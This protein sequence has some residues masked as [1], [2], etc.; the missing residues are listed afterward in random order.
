MRK[1]NLWMLAAILTLCGLTTTLTSCSDS[2]DEVQDKLTP[3][4]GGN[5]NTGYKT[6][7]LISDIHVMSPQLL[8]REGSAYSSYLNFDPKLL[9][10]SANVLESL[11]DEAIKRK[12]DLV[13]IPGDLTKDGELVS[14]QLVASIL[15]RLRTAGIPVILVPG[16]HD[17]DNPEGYYFNGDEKRSAE[18]TSPEMFKQIYADFGYNQAYATDPASLSFVCEPLEGLVLLCLDTNL[19]EE[20]LYKDRGDEKDYNQTAGRIRP[21]TLNWALDEA[22]KARALGKQVVLVEHH[23]I[24]Q[25][26]DAQGSIQSEY[27]IPDYQ[28]ISEKMGKHGVH[29]AFTGHTHLQDIAAYKYYDA[30][31][32]KTDSIVDVATGSTVS[33]PNPWRV[34]RVSDDYTRWEI[35]TEY[36]KSIPQL[37]DVQGTCYKRLYDNISGG[38]EWH[39]DYAWD[40]IK[41]YQQKGYLTLL[42]L[43]KDFLPENA[44]E[45][46]MLISEYL[47]DDL[48]TMFMIHNEGNE[49]QHSES[50][51]LVEKLR[52]DLQQLL[53]DRSQ[54]VGQHDITTSFIESLAGTVFDTQISPGLKSMLSDKNQMNVPYRESRIDD[55]NTVLL[56]EK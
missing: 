47:G 22:D 26:H 55:I 53:H 8:E 21:A 4:D 44:H 32:V 25:H 13:I 16:N 10:Y 15:T 29:L 19:Y 50:A 3:D 46:T 41:S 34:I 43:N 31:K 37:A 23:N 42:G 5:A 28:N 11:V 20:N 18:R 2:K 52:T 6:I 56:I 9:E 40:D 49:W 27:I 48:C 30:L 17:I 14:H 35:A 51:T 38:L 54:A 36:I 45:L 39:I 12:P 24:V 1:L 7:F 33:Y